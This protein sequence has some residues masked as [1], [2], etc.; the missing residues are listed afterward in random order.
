[1]K[2]FPHSRPAY[3]LL[4]L[5]L[6]TT[7]LAVILVMTLQIISSVAGES[8]QAVRQ[9]AARREIDGAI[10][11]SANDIQRG[12]SFSVVSQGIL[13]FAQPQRDEVGGYRGSTVT[14]FFCAPAGALISTSQQT[15]CLSSTLDE[16]TTSVL[17][18]EQAVVRGFTAIPVSSAQGA[19]LGV[20]TQLV[21]TSCAERT[22]TPTR[23]AQQG[24]REQPPIVVT[25][26]M[27]QQPT[28]P[29]PG[30]GLLCQ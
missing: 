29:C 9:T 27:M 22:C 5:L 16:Q 26:F 28:Y 21:A 3:S 20:L 7:V 23:I 2:T 14:R 24:D 25:R 6:A 8:A 4:E 18:S 13:Q 17:T 15:D 1:M 30:S 11:R 12:G 10:A 19:P